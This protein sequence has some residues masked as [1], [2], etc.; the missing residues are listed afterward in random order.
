MPVDF[1]DKIQNLPK[2]RPNMAIELGGFLKNT[3][4]SASL[5]HTAGAR[6]LREVILE[7]ELA[8]I[9]G[10]IYEVPLVTIGNLPAWNLV[11]PVSSQRK[12]IT[13]FSNWNDLLVLGGVQAD[14]KE[15]GHVFVSSDPKPDLWF[16]GIDD[17]WKLGKPVGDG[18]P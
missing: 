16:G 7:R 4:D 15:D 17:L 14:A 3:S 2:A 18:G 11:R 8:N 5:L 6:G 1:K 10:T 13:D 9:H 12:P